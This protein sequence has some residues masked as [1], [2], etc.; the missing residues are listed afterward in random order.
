VNINEIFKDLVVV[1]LASVL[2]GPTVGMFFA[3]LGARV[4]KVEN[5]NTGGDVTRS[6]KLPKE[7]ANDEFS[8]YYHSINWGKEKWML[9]LSA[10]KDR[11]KVVSLIK[12]ADIVISNFKT[13]SAV[14]LEMDYESLKAH[15]PKLIYGAI[16]AYG[17]DDPTPGFD[18][19]IQAETGW[20]FMNG[21]KDGLPVKIP[22]ALIDLLAA[23]QLKQ[24]L[25]VALLKRQMNGEGSF[26]SVSLF[27]ASVA[28]LANQ[29]SNW[30]NVNFLPQRMG[31]QHPNIAPYGDIFQTKDSLDVILGTG[32]QKQFEGLCEILELPFLKTDERFATNALRLV[33]RTALNEYL[34][35]AFREIAFADL[36]AACLK[37]KVTIAPINDMEAV[38][39][40]P[41]AQK[42]I[43]KE[44]L[45]DG[46]EVKTV[47]TTVFKIV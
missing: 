41:N 30:L 12:K 5:K 18:V 1:E 3:E 38:F 32:T 47:R 23:H 17:D 46:R 26:V 34:A 45:A 2:A 6:W 44:T 4:I 28:A 36:K 25:L 33:H 13:D 20:I 35:K 14:K 22:V 27:D 24:G 40:L 37:K 19:M 9:D 43:L 21:E 29:A 11:A 39:N 7:D 16:T 10:S 15:H 8:A 31:S 42:L